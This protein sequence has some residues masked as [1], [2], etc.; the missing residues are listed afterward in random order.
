[1]LKKTAVSLLALITVFCCGAFTSRDMPERAVSAPTLR[2]AAQAGAEDGD[3]GTASYE[4]VDN[5]AEKPVFYFLLV[6]IV[7]A[8]LAASIFL[9]IDMR[10]K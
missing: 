4:N 6:L 7:S 10:K 1:M 5:I 9:I 2:A 8:T 3:D